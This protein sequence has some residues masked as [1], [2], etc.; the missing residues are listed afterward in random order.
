VQL[1]LEVADGDPKTDIWQ[2]A[3]YTPR[4]GSD[5]PVEASAAFLIPPGAEAPD[6]GAKLYIQQKMNP[7]GFIA[8]QRYYYADCGTLLRGEGVAPWE[9]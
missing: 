6:I 5:G 1:V 7:D 8:A 3:M 2:I 4:T 9:D